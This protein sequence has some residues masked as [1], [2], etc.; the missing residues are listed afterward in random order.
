VDDN[1]HCGSGGDK[2]NGGAKSLK[3]AAQRMNVEE[4]KGRRLI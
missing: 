3:V 1:G 4:N 2:I